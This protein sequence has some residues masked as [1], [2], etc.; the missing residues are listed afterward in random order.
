MLKKVLMLFVAF[1][2]LIGCSTQASKPQDVKEEIWNEGKIIVQDITQT[3]DS[4]KPISEEQSQ[5]A[6]LYNY[7]YGKDIASLSNKEREIV[8]GVADLE[9]DAMGMRLTK[10][11]GDTSSYDKALKGY[12]DMSA[13]LKTTY[14]LK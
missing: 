2:L 11:K 12:T 10:F 13:K 14:G 3:I 9:R 6:T 7:K 5:R 8:M 1:A 4:G